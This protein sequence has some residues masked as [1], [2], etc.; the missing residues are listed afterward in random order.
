MENLPAIRARLRLVPTE[1]D[2]RVGWIANDYRPMFC[3]GDKSTH[4]IVRLLR[5]D[6]MYPGEE[7]EVRIL[8]LD[9]EIFADALTNGALFELREGAK[10]TGKGNVLQRP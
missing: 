10:V 1:N 5:G 2:G 4:C 6:R 3:I 7:A 9:A 8:L